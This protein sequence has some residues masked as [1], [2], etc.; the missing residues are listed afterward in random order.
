MCV[1][2]VE[3]GEPET[4]ETKLLFR[5]H[6]HGKSLGIVWWWFLHIEYR[7]NRD[8]NAIKVRHISHVVKG[9]NSLATY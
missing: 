9:E 4:N 5:R 6:P 2:I 1:A 8:A 3:P 7:Y